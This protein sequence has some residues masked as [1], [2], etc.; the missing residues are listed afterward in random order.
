MPPRHLRSGHSVRGQGTTR[1]DPRAVF[2][3]VERLMG[4]GDTHHGTAGTDLGPEDARALLRSW[5]VAMDLDVDESGL[6][7]LLQ[8]RELSHPDLYRR[9]RRL[10]E[11]KLAG[12]VEEL[13]GMAEG[14]QTLDV[15]P[16][17]LALFDACIPAIPYAAATALPWTR[18]AEADT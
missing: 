2:E 13:V 9:A 6:L 7:E 17:A 4:D 3:I 5:L 12:A 11:R 10:H 15:Q 8:E 14:G 1:P 16:G 18:E